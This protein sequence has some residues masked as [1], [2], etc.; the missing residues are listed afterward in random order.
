VIITPDEGSDCELAPFT[1]CDGVDAGSLA[2]DA[3]KL[4]DSAPAYARLDAHRIPCVVQRLIQAGLILGGPPGTPVPEGQA[5]EEVG[6]QV[7]GADHV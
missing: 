2:A 6:T 5:P 1:L 4:Q 3:A 7:P